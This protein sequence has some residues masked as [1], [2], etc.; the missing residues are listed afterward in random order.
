MNSG[1]RSGRGVTQRRGRSASGPADAAGHVRRAMHAL[2][3]TEPA[4]A[5][6]ARSRRIGLPEGA[7]HYLD[8]GRGEPVVLL[9]GGGGGAANWFRLIGPLAAT[10][11]VL[12]PDLPGFG[13]SPL[14]T[15]E[16]ALGEA[17]A[18]VVGGWLDA[19]GV[20]RATVVGTSFGGLTALRLAQ[21][22][23]GMVMRLGLIDSVGLGREATWLL[24]IATLP[25][26]GPLAVRPSR[27]GTA[28]LFRLLLTS[29]RRQLTR[30]QRD[31]LIEY[32]WRSGAVGDPGAFAATIRRFAGLRGQREVLS[33]GE[34]AALKLPVSLIWGRRDRFLP[35]R[36]AVAAAKH[37]PRAT[38][39][40]I[41]DVGHSPN[42]EAPDA[43]LAAM[44]ALLD[45][46]P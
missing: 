16:G 8:A 25:L 35:V 45:V 22:R 38:F 33:A 20:A 34:L 2:L 12:A 13:L 18:G 46:P 14:R 15:A 7:I 41:D 44:R 40:L 42:W 17:A 4:A 10:H 23:P 5:A 32:V 27:A 1:G 29:N 36:H 37:L 9:H 31:A 30:A 6:V 28:L 11:R 39:T 19:V 26:L 21:Q 3:A 24:R 43:V